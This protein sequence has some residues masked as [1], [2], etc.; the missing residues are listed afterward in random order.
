MR[1]IREA[2][3][4]VDYVGISAYV[5]QVCRAVG[6]G[7]AFEAQSMHVH[8]QPMVASVLLKR[9]M[10]P[11]HAVGCMPT[12]VPPLTSGGSTTANHLDKRVVSMLCPTAAGGLPAVRHGEPDEDGGG[13]LLAWC[14]LSDTG[15]PEAAREP[16]GVCASLT[17]GEATGPHLSPT[18]DPQMDIEFAYYNLTLQE[19][20]DMGKEIHVRR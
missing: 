5:P 19:L 1:G 10:Y 2:F 13:L 8:W 16:A 7:L 17:A 12:S 9:K 6:W 18:C 11:H 15:C 3:T 4:S 14:T 20:V